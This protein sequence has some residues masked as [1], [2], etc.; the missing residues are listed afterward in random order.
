MPREMNQ[1]TF[2]TLKFPESWTLKTYRSIGG[3]EAW[4]KILKEKT[5]PEK[6][7]EELKASGLRGRGGAFLGMKL[8]FV[9]SG[10]PAPP[11]P[12]SPEA[13]SSS[14]S[15]SGGVFSL[16]IFSHAW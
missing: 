2:E 4:E 13:F 15:F 9:P 14:I 3:Y 6:L 8:H 11:R 5:P 10:K 7:I 1:V 16:R 12:L